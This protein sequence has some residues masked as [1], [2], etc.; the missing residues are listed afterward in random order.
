MAIGKT[1]LDLLELTTILS[2]RI[3]LLIKRVEKLENKPNKEK[4]NDNK[5]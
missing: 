3:D 2:E 5:T 1:I 4:E